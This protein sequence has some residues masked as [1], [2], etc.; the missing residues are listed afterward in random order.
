MGDKRSFMSL[1]L[2]N[3]N[4]VNITSVCVIVILY[5]SIIVCS[6]DEYCSVFIKLNRANINILPK[7][8][9]FWFSFLSEKHS[10]LMTMLLSSLKHMHTS[11]VKPDG[12]VSSCKQKEERLS[13]DH[14]PPLLSVCGCV[15]VCVCDCQSHL[16]KFSPRGLKGVLH[17][18]ICW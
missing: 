4:I 7:Q 11:D 14:I 15:C 18:I 3:S 16:W 12:Q 5:M 6:C 13:E 9:W 17:R 10:L 1:K 2:W 8:S